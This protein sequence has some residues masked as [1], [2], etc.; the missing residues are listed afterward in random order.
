MRAALSFTNKF[1]RFSGAL[2]YTSIL[3]RTAALWS[4]PTGR[5]A[6][7]VFTASSAVR[8]APPEMHLG[9]QSATAF[10]LC[11]VNWAS[12]HFDGPGHWLSL[13]ASYLYASSSACKPLLH[14]SHTLWWKDKAKPHEGLGRGLEA[15]G[16]HSLTGLQSWSWT[17]IILILQGRASQFHS[18][19]SKVIGSLSVSLE[20]L[21]IW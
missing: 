18:L 5:A 17:L 21:F 11:C 1:C 13:R 4:D 9:L 16:R 20:G 10:I 6:G 12:S 14:P 19:P 2:F 7:G 3:N 8:V 15:V